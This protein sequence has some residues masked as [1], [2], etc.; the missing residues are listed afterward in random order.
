[1]KELTAGEIFFHGALLKKFTV[2][3]SKFSVRNKERLPSRS[4]RFC[5]GDEEKSC[6]GKHS[7]E[8]ESLSHR[9]NSSRKR[10]QARM[11]VPLSE[12]QSVQIV[13]TDF[14]VVEG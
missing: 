8:R 2:V 11:L 12:T 9:D 5:A 13:V 1:M 3:G 10:R 7:G 6:D 4:L 14:Y